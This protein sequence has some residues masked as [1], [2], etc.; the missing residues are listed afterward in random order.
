MMNG[1]IL[2]DTKH[3]KAM[4]EF[5]M[6]QAR[7]ESVLDPFIFLKCLDSDNDAEE[8]ISKENFCKDAHQESFEDFF[9]IMELL[10]SE[11]D[12]VPP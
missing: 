12:L 6:W 10:N 1:C 3:A 2:A 7:G 11:R 4:A 5:I 9:E 8:I